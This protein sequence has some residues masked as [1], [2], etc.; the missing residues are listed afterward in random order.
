VNDTVGNVLL[1]RPRP[2]L[3]LRAQ[4]TKGAETPWEVPRPRFGSPVDRASLLEPDD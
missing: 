4:L 2:E 1:N 3:K